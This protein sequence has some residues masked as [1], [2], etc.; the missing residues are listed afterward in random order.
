MSSRP[1]RRQAGLPT[2]VTS[3]VP[4]RGPAGL[5]PHCSC[6]DSKRSRQG[7]AADEI[8]QFALTGTASDA[9]RYNTAAKRTSS[10][11]DVIFRYLETGLSYA[12][13][14]AW[15]LFEAVKSQSVGDAFPP[16]TLAIGPEFS[17]ASSGR[18]ALA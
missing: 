5:G 4:K 8:S 7:V 3:L 18:R 14:G 13:D 17:N 2:P 1:S 12:A 11:T 15:Q 9:D 16:R 10:G 6:R